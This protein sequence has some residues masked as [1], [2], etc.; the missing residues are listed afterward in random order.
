[1]T[2]NKIFWIGAGVIVG[3]IALI[4]LL[5][6]T[7]NFGSSTKEIQAMFK[8][9]KYQ[10]EKKVYE[11]EY[12]NIKIISVGEDTTKPLLVLVHGSPGSWDAYA[13]YLSDC[14]LQEHFRM[15]SLD[16][17]GYGSNFKG[18]PEASVFKQAAIL[19]PVIQQNR[20]KAKV[21]MMGHSYGGPVI[22]RYAMDYPEEV[23]GLFFIAPSIDP[24]QEK[25]KWYQ[26][27]SASLLV[28]WA[29]PSAIDVCNREILPLKA[30]LT[31]MLP[32]WDKITASVWHFHGT[33]DVLVPYEN[34]DFA[35]KMLKNVPFERIDFEGE[36]HFILW[37]KMDTIKQYL[38]KLY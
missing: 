27:A 4:L 22:A 23:D 13:K 35:Q 6:N 10:P 8:E 9:K 24:K 33:K 36:N 38:L 17:W 20:Y 15:I 7:M 34:A 28:R 29:L 30:E 2:W 31:E 11:S 32:L 12:G 14:D 19:H 16:R 37:T 25:V 1:M 3:L 26:N 21:Y 18:K 5:L